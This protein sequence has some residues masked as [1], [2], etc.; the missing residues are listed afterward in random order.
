MEYFRYMR[1]WVRMH[2]HT[3][4]TG[5]SDVEVMES[6]A[7][8]P[9]PARTLPEW[10]TLVNGEPEEEQPARRIDP[11]ERLKNEGGN[12]FKAGIVRIGA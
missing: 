9:L 2:T 1:A 4:I 10:S 7:L 5:W 3:D 6:F 12:L 11:V 8:L